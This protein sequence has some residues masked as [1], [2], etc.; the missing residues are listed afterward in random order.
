MLTLFLII[1]GLIVLIGFAI[2]G[3]LGAPWVPAFKRDLDHILD[4]SGLEA[5][6]LYIEL[7]AGDGRLVAAAAKRGARAIGYEINPVMCLVAA[8]RNLRYYPKA[9]IRL[10]NFWQ[11]D[12]SE[13]DV[14][15]VFLMPK[16]MP[17]LEQKLTKELKPGSVLVSYIFVLPSRRPVI[18][19]H[20]WSVYHF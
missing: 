1:L 13:A 5:G 11:V 12:L 4:D 6:Q 8:V 17:R 15:L 9:K 20:H 16:F 7:G 2:A 14:V 19:R 18:K 10:A 3:P